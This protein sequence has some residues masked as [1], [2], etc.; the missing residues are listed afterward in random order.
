MKLKGKRSLSRT[1]A[2]KFT[3][4]IFLA[5]MVL[6]AAMFFLLRHLL[7]NNDQDIAKARFHEIVKV[8][9]VSGLESLK[10]ETEKGQFNKLDE[11]LIVIWDTKGNK[12]F[13][14]LPHK[15]KNFDVFKIQKAL[16]KGQNGSLTI[17]PER[18]LEETIET[19]IGNVGQ[20]HIAVGI[21]TDS[22]EDFL[23]LYFKI[24]IILTFISGLCSVLLG[25]GS[26]KKALQPINELINAV[27][28][29]QK[30]KWMALQNNVQS[31]DE[32]AELT[33]LF[34]DMISQIQKLIYS[35]QTSIDFIAHDLRTP[36]THLSNKIEN[37]LKENKLT[38]K[39]EFV[40]DLMEETQSIASLINTLLEISEADSQS[41]VLHKEFFRLN[42]LIKEC[43][44]LY[45][46]VS[47]ERKA[48]IQVLMNEELYVNADRNKLKRVVANLIDNALKYSPQNPQIKITAQRKDLHLFLSLQDNGIGIPEDD[49]AKIWQ[50]LYRGDAS[51]TTPGMGLGLSFVKSIVDAHQWSIRA[52]PTTHQS[53]S[54]FIIE[55]PLSDV[56]NG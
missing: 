43:V 3:A 44:E 50:R 29:V 40:E 36:L 15:L 7:S 42:D 11:M 25:Y 27:K 38:L 5:N 19:Y 12:L 9:E 41:L 51:R 28:L 21:N 54:I 31:N 13:E 45:E 1:I 48:N 22:S 49:L 56:I 53:G 55:I 30:G 17:Y 23:H 6:I 37:L 16:A 39:R 10:E 32:L 34:N 14:K 4:I 20:Y 46:Y 33:N 35:L 47:E 8:I 2:L 24:S 18:I 26:T 52:E